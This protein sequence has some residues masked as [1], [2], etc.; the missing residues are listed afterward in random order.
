MG[1]A[2]KDCSNYMHINCRRDIGSLLS[3]FINMTY[4]HYLY[5][6]NGTLRLVLLANTHDVTSMK[7][8]KFSKI[9][10]NFIAILKHQLPFWKHVDEVMRQ[11]SMKQTQNL[12][13]I[14]SLVYTVDN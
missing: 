4:Y 3:N 1:K 13:E 8:Q 9:N 11:T 10:I 6:L 7:I 12:A 2:L 14:Q 5:F